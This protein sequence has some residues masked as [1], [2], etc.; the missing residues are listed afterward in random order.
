MSLLKDKR[1]F[2]KFL[3]TQAKKPGLSASRRKVWAE[4]SSN[5]II[6]HVAFTK[7]HAKWSAYRGPITDFWEWLIENQDEVFAILE[8][9]L[10]FILKVVDLFS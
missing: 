7:V 9:L 4:A 5:P 3:A 1:T 10:E 8:K 2:V 6:Q